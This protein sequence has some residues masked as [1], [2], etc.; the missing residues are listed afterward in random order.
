MTI[1]EKQK[2]LIEEFKKYPTWEEKYKKMI[3]FGKL[4]PEME[5]QHK[6]E[7]NL[8]KGCQSQVWLYASLTSQG[9]V[10]FQA[11]SDAL[12]VKGLIAVLL[13]VYN[14]LKPEE[15]LSISSDFIKAM[16]F[17]GHLS[18]SR[19]NGLVAMIQQIRNYAT[20]YQYL[21]QTRK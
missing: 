19:A 21:L 12:I 17:E 6:E 2:L 3:E 16:G 5:T 4:L 8:V 14:D 9:I 15:I 1:D 20:A 13:K 7:K 10:H 11:D 18:P